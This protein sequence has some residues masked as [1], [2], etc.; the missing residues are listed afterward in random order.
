L[1]ASN[2]RSPIP[3]ADQEFSVSNSPHF[4]P[5][6]IL[7][8]HRIFK[9]LT[10]ALGVTGLLMACGEGEIEAPPAPEVI[11]TKVIQ[12]DQPIEMEFVGETR[13]SADIPI[14]ARVE[15]VILGMH[16]TEGQRVEEGDLLYNIDP[17]PFQAKV[18][19]AKGYLAEATTMVAKAKSDLDRIRPLAEMN[20]VSK[21]DLDGAQAQYD[22]ALGNLQA[23][24]ARL[25]Q[26]EIERSYAEIKSPIAG[27]IGITAARVGEFVGKSPNPVVLNFVSLTN[28]IRVRYSIDERSYLKF[29]RRMREMRNEMGTEEGAQVENRTELELVLTDGSIHDHRGRTVAFD[30]AIDPSTGTFTLEADFPNPD[31]IVLAGQ[32]ARIRADVETIEDALLVPVRSIRELQGIF[33]VFVVGSDGVVEL[34]TIE[35]GPKVGR[36]QVV[37]KGLEA[38]EQIALETMRLRSGMTVT[39]K[40]EAPKGE[41]KPSK[42]APGGE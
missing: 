21:Q 37:A 41:T 19:E 23:G 22:A 38:G 17:A 20:A 3:A 11:V 36:L 34:R 32:F 28:P 26:A 12:R 30:A 9:Q 8:P 14:R 2:P 4:R 29:A 25:E 15:G 16:F 42:S 5:K 40:I 33:Q 27:R 6:L 7:S 18:V 24:E 10:V 1:T 35:L 13:G 31:E 39:P